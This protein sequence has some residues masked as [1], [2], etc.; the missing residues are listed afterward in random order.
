MD[1]KKSDYCQSQI[2]LVRFYGIGIFVKLVMSNTA[3]H[4]LVRDMVNV[5]TAIESSS[6]LTLWWKWPK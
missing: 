2:D 1:R 6:S 3:W 4:S 5:C